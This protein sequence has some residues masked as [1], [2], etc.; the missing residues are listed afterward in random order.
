MS[1]NLRTR[2]GMPFNFV[3]GLKVRGMD[4]ESLIPGIEGIPEAGSKYQFAGNGSNKAFTLPVT[5]YNKDAIDVYVKQLYV[6]PDD[7]TLVGDTVT[8]T[9]APPA[10]VAGETYNVVIK[11]SLT[12]LNGYVN[13][14]RVSFEGENLDDILEKG[15]PLANYSALR[16]YAGAATQVRITDPGIAGFFYYDAADTTSADN[17]GT[18]IVSSNGKRWKRLFEG[19][20]NVKWFGAKGDGASSVSVDSVALPLAL[21]YQRST[22]RRLFFPKGNYVYDGPTIT[23]NY[24]FSQ[25]LFWEGE[26]STITYVTVDSQFLKIY[27]P[28]ICEVSGIKF[29]GPGAVGADPNEADGGF[30]LYGCAMGEIKNCSFT[31]FIGDGLMISGLF[32]ALPDQGRLTSRNLSIHNNFFDNNGR[33]GLTLISGDS[34][35]IF[36][37]TF[38]PRTLASAPVIFPGLHIEADASD[39]YPVDNIDVF[40]NTIYAYVTIISQKQSNLTGVVDSRITFRDNYVSVD[41]QLAISAPGCGNLSILNNTIKSSFSGTP[42]TSWGLIWLAGGDITIRDNVVVANVA[43]NLFHLRYWKSLGESKESLV[44]KDNKCSYVSSPG[45]NSVF[46]LIGDTGYYSTK[47]WDFIDISGEYE[48]PTSAYFL[49]INPGVTAVKARVSNVRFSGNI[50]YFISFGANIPAGSLIKVKS[51]NANCTS[52]SFSIP[53]TVSYVLLVSDDSYITGP[54]TGAGGSITG[55]GTAVA[56]TRINLKNTTDVSGVPQVTGISSF[57]GFMSGGLTKLSTGV[58]EITGAP[59]GV[60]AYANAY[61]ALSTNV[62]GD[63]RLQLSNAGQTSSANM[64]LLCYSAGVLTDLPA[65]SRVAITLDFTPVL[66]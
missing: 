45:F 1:N 30:M 36:S 58:Y 49:S 25:S 5:P 50:G 43:T 53:N 32:D 12:T 23:L 55:S 56:P 60:V 3:N 38:G 11:V 19:A 65:S 51:T 62:N 57:P 40:G 17:G 2:N 31:N 66:H 35:S 20:V 22:G 16:A 10:V 41:T 14:S 63:Y 44:I 64:R 46:R 39:R 54:I 47:T 24:T 6:H 52:A 9:E 61:A 27:Q 29:V 37:N 34:V 13:A 42:N 21:Y 26:E 4:I 18:I 59:I 15:K 48:V 8:L 28:F 33:G 7:Y